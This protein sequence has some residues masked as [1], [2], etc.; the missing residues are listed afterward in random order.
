MPDLVWNWQAWQ[1]LYSWQG[2][3]EEWSESWG[4]SRA[5]WF[6]ALLPRIHPWL[7][8]GAVLEIGCGHGRWTQ[9][10]LQHCREYWGID[11]APRCVDFCAK[12]FAAIPWA[13][14]FVNDGKALDMVPDEHMD[15]IFSFDSL[16]HVE[17]DVLQSYLPQILKKLAP[18]GVAFLHHSNWLGAAETVNAHHRG[19]SVSAV[20]VREC[21]EGGGGQVLVQEIIEWGGEDNR[22]DCLTTFIR[23]ENRPL[24]EPLL[25]VNDHFMQE[26]ALIRMFQS[27]YSRLQPW[28]DVAR[29]KKEP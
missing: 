23:G 2:E 9:Y 27:H 11:L 19:E 29:E 25:L 15:F 6:G 1:E 22:L 7:P 8:A 26:A 18:R 12:R 5:Q 14:F 16:V 4:G 13:R 3:G 24:R 21:I 20:R 28:K 17:M 10:L